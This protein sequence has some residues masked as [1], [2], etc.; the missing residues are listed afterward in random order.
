MTRRAG[1]RSAGAGLAPAPLRRPASRTILVWKVRPADRAGDTEG[2]GPGEVFGLP[3]VPEFGARLDGDLRGDL[4]EA[5][6]FLSRRV[7][8]LAAGI[9]PG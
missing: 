4:R 8:C 3:L 1:L 5:R 6:H 2:E 7:T 9:N